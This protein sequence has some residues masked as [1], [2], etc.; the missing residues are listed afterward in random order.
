M[1]R[2][3]IQGTL[4]SPAD[5]LWWLIRFDWLGDQDEGVKNNVHIF[6]SGKS[7]MEKSIYVLRSENTGN[8]TKFVGEDVEVVM[9]EEIPGGDVQGIQRNIGATDNFETH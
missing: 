6:G 7:W 3:W 9:P 4:E 8:K 2:R 5:G 1:E